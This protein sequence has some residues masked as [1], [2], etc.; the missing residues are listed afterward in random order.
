MKN[1]NISLMPTSEDQA[2]EIIRLLSKFDCEI[3]INRSDVPQKYVFGCN[4]V[5][6]SKLGE[7]VGRTPEEYQRDMDYF[8]TISEILNKFGLSPNHKGF[9]YAI[10]GIRLITTYGLDDFNMNNDI[11]PIIA[12]W[13]GVSE[14]SVEHNIRNSISA[15]WDR[16][17][18]SPEKYR[19]SISV[20]MNKPTN[21]KFLKYIARMTNYSFN[22]AS[23]VEI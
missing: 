11:Y 12:K 16:M 1:L 17:I 22:D 6:F 7:R 19:S 5:S 15:A 9:R 4:D 3:T 14:T 2:E 10:E 18:T 8:D 23:A 20:F 21:V 13:Y